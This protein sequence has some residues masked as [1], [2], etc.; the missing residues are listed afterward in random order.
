MAAGNGAFTLAP[1]LPIDALAG[2]F[3]GRRRLH[4]PGVLTPQSAAAMRGV[5]LAET[6]WQIS[7]NSGDRH[8]DLER[9][10]IE[11]M[12]PGQVAT[13]ARLI[14]AGA[15]RGFQYL[16]D[17]FSLA[18]AR[19]QAR[20]LTPGL[21]AVLDFFTGDAFLDL[22]RAITKDARIAFADCQA[23]LYRPGHFLTEHDDAVEGKGRLYAYVMNL[24]PDWRADFGGLL[25]FPGADGHVEAAFVPA[26]NALNLFAVPM[27]HLVTA[28]VPFAPQGRLSVTGWLRA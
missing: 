4:V 23:T 7:T 21:R 5:L 27:P 10:Q 15:A 3:S 25:A 14:N 6:P 20:A 19:D 17:T 26:F 12:T 2:A 28:I 16:F 9:A 13:A 24:T 1:A 22:A 8:I 18:D 11:A